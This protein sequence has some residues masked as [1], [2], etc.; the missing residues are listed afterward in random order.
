MLDLVR[1]VMPMTL[2]SAHALSLIANRG[3]EALYSCED[4]LETVLIRLESEVGDRVE[5]I[6]SDLK[7]SASF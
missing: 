6:A 4:A 3:V 5:F 7:G 2:T 1:K